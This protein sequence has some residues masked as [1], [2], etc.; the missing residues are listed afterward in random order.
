MASDGICTHNTRI[1]TARSASW[2]TPSKALSGCSLPPYKYASLRVTGT[3]WIGGKG[4]TCTYNTQVISPDR[5]AVYRF[6]DSLGRLSHIDWRTF[7]WHTVKESNPARSGLESNL[8]PAPGIWRPGKELPLAK[9][10]SLSKRE[11]SG[12][13]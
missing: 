11:G 10:L 5:S 12:Q 8:R 4:R 9:P 3:G 7:P 2:R 6:E 13:M 1:Q